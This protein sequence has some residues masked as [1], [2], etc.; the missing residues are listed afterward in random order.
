MSS[1]R[2]VKS[3]TV[4]V[5]EKDDATLRREFG[6]ACYSAFIQLAKAF[7]RYFVGD[8]PPK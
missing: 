1:A 2:L 3:T 6:L 5:I 8:E 4:V 7:Y